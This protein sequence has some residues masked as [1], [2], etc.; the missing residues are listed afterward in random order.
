MSNLC[1]LPPFGW[2]DE[3]SAEFIPLDAGLIARA[4]DEDAGWD[5]GFAAW[6]LTESSTGSP[7]SPPA[8][9]PIAAASAPYSPSAP[10]S[11]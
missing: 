2:R 1:L 9:L 8:P 6:H 11:R 3:D 4:P 7:F 5:D 10:R